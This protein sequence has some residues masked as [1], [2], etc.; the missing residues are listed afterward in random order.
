MKDKK[1]GKNNK[2]KIRKAGQ[3]VWSNKNSPARGT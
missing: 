1:S 2:K 3:A